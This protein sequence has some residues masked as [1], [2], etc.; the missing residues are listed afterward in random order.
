MGKTVNF[1]LTI[2]VSG[3]DDGRNDYKKQVPINQFTRNITLIKRELTELAKAYSK[4]GIIDVAN[5]YRLTAGVV[6]E[7][8]VLINKQ[9]TRF[10]ETLQYIESI[11]FII[12]DNDYYMIIILDSLSGIPLE[13]MSTMIILLD[14][15]IKK[16]EKWGLSTVKFTTKNN[17]MIITIE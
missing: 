14:K 10:L 3:Y 5:A 7:I 2:R 4:R 13:V 6:S 1:N 17:H 8:V 12:T 15:L 16:T 11:D 9:S